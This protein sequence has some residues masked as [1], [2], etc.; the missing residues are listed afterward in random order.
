MT[1]RSF[2]PSIVSSVSADQIAKQAGA[3]APQQVVFCDFDGPIVDVSERY[4]QT[5]CAGLK[6]IAGAVAQSKTNKPKLNIQ[7]LPKSQ[8]WH[9][10]QNRIADVEIAIRSGLPAELFTPFMQ[11]V[12]RLVNHP[13]L[14]QWDCLQP[15]AEK[16]LRYFEQCQM[17]LVLVTLR[18]P[19][20]VQAILQAHG[21]TPLVHEV[22]GALDAN[23]AFAN[24][25]EQ[26]R[27]LLRRAIA[28][29]KAQGYLTQNSW[30]VGDT[31][32]DVLAGQSAGLFTAAL[33][34]GTRSKAYL[35]GLKPDRIYDCL[36]VAATELG[37]APVLQAA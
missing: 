9:M 2:S 16:A 37:K 36:M 3:F 8:F 7:P 22:Y 35:Q 34:C 26:K 12:E 17:R 14:L 20:Q 25:V 19:R 18:H 21:L 23:A 5:Y 29:Q 28:Q 33:S 11:Q 10:K 4:Y 31:E 32:A 30:M 15:Q 13:S 6:A 24:C 1:V 27:E